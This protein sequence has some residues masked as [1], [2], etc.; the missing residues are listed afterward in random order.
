MRRLRRGGGGGG[1][2]V[3]PMG[4][5]PRGAPRAGQRRFVEIPDMATERKRF[6]LRVVSEAVE[7]VCAVPLRI[8]KRRSYASALWSL[9][10]RRPSARRGSACSISIL[11]VCKPIGTQESAF[12]F[13]YSLASAYKQARG[14]LKRCP[15][16]F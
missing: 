6:R 5:D 13:E 11:L 7:T 16:Q 8:A 10:P 3:R 1:G 9:G 12:V 14:T 2:G 15:L 4:Q